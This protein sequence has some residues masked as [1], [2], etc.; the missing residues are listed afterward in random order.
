MA[1]IHTAALA[2]LLGLAGCSADDGPSFNMS[3]TPTAPGDSLTIRR[4]LGDTAAREVVQSD[5]NL[6]WMPAEA[7]RSTL[8]NPDEAMRDI[9]NY[10][11]V[12]RPELERDLRRSP[13]PPQT[14]APRPRSDATP[15]R[16]SS[17]PAPSAAVATNPVPTVPRVNAFA[18]PPAPPARDTAGQVVAVPGRPPIVTGSGA[19]GVTPYVQPGGAG[20][21]MVP[22]GPNS[23]TLLG[24]DGSVQVV[25]R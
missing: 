21:V 13:A 25:P 15:P 1:V 22:N 5:P 17:G 24:N 12:A 4:V 16:G 3:S 14:P 11:P 19:G 6:G 9:P 20:G 18:P 10:N 8:A 23:A 2:A 7:P